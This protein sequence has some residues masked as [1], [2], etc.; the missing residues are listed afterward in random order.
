MKLLLGLLT[1]A[2]ASLP[3]VSALAQGQPPAAPNTPAIEN[4]SSVRLE[5]T[6]KDDAGT[7]LDS[8]K[9]QEPLSYRQ[10]D[11]E[12]IPGLERQLL[13]MR[14]GDEK[15]VVVK[16]EDG[17]G[18]ADPDAKTEVAKEVLPPGSVVVGTQLL[19]QSPSGER[20]PV[21]VKEVKDKT[22]VLDLNHPLAGKTLHFDVKVISVQPPK[23]PE[24][25]DAPAS[26]A[27]PPGAKP[28]K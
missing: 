8:N 3:A 9:G 22:V 13:G 21:T 23:A 4:G 12:I 25:K 11:E 1:V 24:T 27:P 6:L 19:A 10:G 5:Y 14:A 18:A 7:V 26:G 17:Y 2:L 16:P 15:K 20:R 28:E